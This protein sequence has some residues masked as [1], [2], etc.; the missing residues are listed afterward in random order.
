MRSIY[1]VRDDLRIHD[2]R[3]LLEF[4]QQTK[5]GVLIW[6]TTPS[7]LRADEIRRNFILHS[8]FDFKQSIAR[9]GGQLLIFD[10]PAG[11]VLPELVRS[12]NAEAI[13]CTSLPTHEEL[14][15]ELKIESWLG[16]GLRRDPQTTLIHPDDLP[17]PL[18]AVPEL[19]TEF[20]KSVEKHLVLKPEVTIP[21]RLPGVEQWSMPID[22]WDTLITEW[23]DNRDSP[24]S[25][26]SLIPPGE[27]AGLERI[28]SYF[29]RTNRVQTYKKTRNGLLEWD[30]SAKLSP[31]LSVG[32][33][34]PRRIYFEL[35]RYEHER[36]QN[37]STYWLFLELLWRDYFKFI[38]KKW[39]PT[40]FRSMREMSPNWSPILE[41]TVDQDST[42][43]RWCR[44]D[45]DNR[46]INANMRELNETGWMSNRGRQ[47]VASFLAKT[48]RVDWRRGA[49]YFEKK[50]IDYDASS[51]WGN[52]SYLAGVGQDSRD[53]V[54]NP[55]TQAALYD[56]RG[57][58]RNRWCP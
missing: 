21:E 19:F 8:L 6:C 11:E 23:P 12:F 29:W 31:Y 47:N 39:G 52:W 57:D 35:K 53:R 7:F 51:N 28:G 14:T 33:L 4:A 41:Q 26:H 34:S 54:F 37:E 44:G 42:F 22:G 1:W 16:P 32:A 58:Y 25:G 56:P 46:F 2:N 3:V 48:I 30:D 55:E 5:V 10:R 43:S 45:T 17:Y 49:H 38:A 20:R 36:G 15:E 13:F 27:R 18:E 24:F 50:L 9:L 40:F